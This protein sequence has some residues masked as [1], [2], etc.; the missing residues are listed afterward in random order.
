MG[1]LS[2]GRGELLDLRHAP[3]QRVPGTGW[4]D[5]LAAGHL[6]YA[7]NI[8]VGAEL[9]V[10]RQRVSDLTAATGLILPP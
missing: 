3:D 9:R 5:P 1:L 7:L 8:E 4:I 10:E 6:E 2:T